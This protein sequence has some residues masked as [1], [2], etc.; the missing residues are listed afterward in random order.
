MT[1]LVGIRGERLP[2]VGIEERVDDALRH[3]EDTLT[4]SLMT[5]ITPPMVVLTDRGHAVDPECGVMDM[6]GF[7]A[8]LP[9]TDD[10][11]RDRGLIPL[12]PLFGVDRD[13]PCVWLK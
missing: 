3:A 11:Q 8:W 6:L 4:R 12:P 2:G 9:E 10:A 5:G 1:R 13:P 7:A